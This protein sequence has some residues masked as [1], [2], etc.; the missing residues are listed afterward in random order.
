MSPFTRLQRAEE[1]I[2]I[3]RT[4]ESVTPLAQIDPSILQIFN[5]EEIVR[6]LAAIN[7]AP[8]RMLRTPEQIAMLKQMQAQQQQAA[9]LLE[10]APVA[11]QTA[12]TL[13]EAQQIESQG[14]PAFVPSYAA[15]R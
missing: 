15:G 8:L 9:A 4:L 10:A 2:G 13:A 14:Q 12:K 3:M 6:S 11:A 1:G 5:P 7:G